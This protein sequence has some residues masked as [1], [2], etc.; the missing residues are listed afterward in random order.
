MPE[1]AATHEFA[2]YQNGGE[3]Q[4]IFIFEN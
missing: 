4:Q 2:F 1:R 3:R